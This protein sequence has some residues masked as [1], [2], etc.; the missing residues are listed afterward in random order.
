MMV[1]ILIWQASWAWWKHLLCTVCVLAVVAGVSSAI[2][3]ER[4]RK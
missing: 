2:S 4:R 3:V 1:M